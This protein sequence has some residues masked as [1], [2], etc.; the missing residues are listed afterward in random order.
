[1]ARRNVISRWA[2]G[3]ADRD[4]PVR[5]AAQDQLRRARRH[6]RLRGTDRAIPWTYRQFYQ[7]RAIRARQRRAVGHG[8]P[9]RRT[10]TAPPESALRIRTRGVGAVCRAGVARIRD[11]GVGA[12]R[13]AWRRV[14]RRLRHRAD[15]FGK[16]S[17]FSN[18]P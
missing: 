16:V 9:P 15:H 13:A 18:E 10:A 12:A 5:A 7:R 4:F 8:I 1:M 11:P 3:R 2:F 6:R 17:T 14:L